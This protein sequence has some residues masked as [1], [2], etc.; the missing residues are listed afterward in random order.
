MRFRSANPVIGRLTHQTK[1]HASA[2]SATYQG[3][4]MKSALLLGIMVVFGVISA[5]RVFGSEGLTTG[6][7]IFLIASPIIA[8]IS[9]FIAMAK[10][11]VAPFFSII[12]AICQGTFVGFLS[13]LY[14]VAFGGGIVLTAVTATASVFGG[15]LLLYST[16]LF[17]V[18]QQLR[19]ILLTALVGLIFTS[20]FVFIFSMLGVIDTSSEGFIT[21][22][23]AISVISV[24]VASL[25]LMVDF[26]NIRTL[27]SNGADKQYE[28]VLSLGLLVTLVW[29]YVELLRLIA[30]L[31]SRR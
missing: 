12:Y 23:F 11:Q 6:T 5:S 18:S 27:V 10:P 29:L 21:I 14:E 1:S 15:M 13:G 4:V 8:L 30:I 26:D 16:G 2:Y 9:V 22:I 31:R 20:F 7:L 3:V 19:R 28:W 25:F 24:V 17:R